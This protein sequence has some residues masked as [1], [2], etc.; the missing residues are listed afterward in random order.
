LAAHLIETGRLREVELI[1]RDIEAALARKG[2]VVAEIASAHEL[3]AATRTAITSYLKHA[4]D[5]K[6]VQLNESVQPEL[7]GGVRIAVPGAE[8]DASLRR[9]IMKLRAAKV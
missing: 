9:K 6:S 1:T 7:L 4:T 5:A 8:M 2:V 3:T